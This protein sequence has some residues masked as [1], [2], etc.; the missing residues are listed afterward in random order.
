MKPKDSLTKN[1]EKG[2]SDGKAKLFTE[3]LKT[4]IYL[5]Q[6]EKEFDFIFSAV[7]KYYSQGESGVFNF[8][9]GMPLMRC[10]YNLNLT[11]KMYEMVMNQVSYGCL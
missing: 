6:N 4:L 1:I 8:H 2:M 10:A 9:F 5:T 3:D 7:K 11:D